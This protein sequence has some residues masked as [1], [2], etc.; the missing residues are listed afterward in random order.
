MASDPI[1]PNQVEHATEQQADFWPSGLVKKMDNDPIGPKQVEHA[2]EL[3]PDFW[4][5]GLV[6]KTGQ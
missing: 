1:G 6:K 3:Q 4:A 2:T 5:S